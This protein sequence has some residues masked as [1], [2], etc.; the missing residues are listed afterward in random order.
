MTF[1]PQ[2]TPIES[3]THGLDAL[4][5]SIPSGDPVSALIIVKSC[6]KL[7]QVSKEA[8]QDKNGKELALLIGYLLLIL[9]IQ[10]S[11]Q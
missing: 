3:L 9:D 8:L 7:E 10:A 4:V 6:Q 11:F 5:R 2:I 1:F